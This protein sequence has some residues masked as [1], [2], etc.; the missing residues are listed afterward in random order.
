MDKTVSE[1][2]EEVKEEMCKE[3]CKNVE[4]CS[5]AIDNNEDYPCPLDRL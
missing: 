2:I 3:F 1:I 5:E 4:E